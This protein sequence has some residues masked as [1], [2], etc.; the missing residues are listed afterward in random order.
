MRENYRSE[1]AKAFFTHDE[2]RRSTIHDI[3]L[4]IRDR[5]RRE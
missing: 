2:A 4:A 1:G 5:E 3:N